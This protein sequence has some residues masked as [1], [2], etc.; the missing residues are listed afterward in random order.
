MSI[1]GEYNGTM[2]DFLKIYKC[3]G[4]GC[5]HREKEYKIFKKEA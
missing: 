2:Y 3:E 1:F 4:N 5:V